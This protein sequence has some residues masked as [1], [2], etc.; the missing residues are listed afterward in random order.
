MIE[1]K[2]TNELSYTIEKWDDGTWRVICSG[3]QS[4]PYSTEN[5]AKHE[6]ELIHKEEELMQKICSTFSSCVADGFER[7]LEELVSYL[8]RKK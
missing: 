6:L 4:D 3:L 8:V 2:W 1:I 7:A 5:E